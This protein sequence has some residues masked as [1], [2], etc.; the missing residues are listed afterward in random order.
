MGHPGEA[1]SGHR[2]WRRRVHT[3]ILGQTL[4]EGSSDEYCN[5]PMANAPATE[6]GCNGLKGP[7]GRPTFVRWSSFYPLSR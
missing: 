7:L 6:I 5:A 1:N 3:A 2:R 4:D